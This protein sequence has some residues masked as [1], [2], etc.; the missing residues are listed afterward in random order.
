MWL[1][2]WQAMWNGQR[3]IWQPTASSNAT[4][5]LSCPT[6]RLPPMQPRAGAKHDSEYVYAHSVESRGGKRESEYDSAQCLESGG[7]EHDA[8]DGS[9]PS[10]ER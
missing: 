9:A 7:A 8:E 10:A 2:R 1:T 3:C 6:S 4:L 5:T